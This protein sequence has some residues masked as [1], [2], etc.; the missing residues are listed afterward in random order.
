MAAKFSPAPRCRGLVPELCSPLERAILVQDDSL[1]D[2]CCPG[3]EIRKT[4]VEW[5]YSARFIMIE[6]SDVEMTGNA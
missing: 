6:G 2:Q 4:N 3:Q 1:V 5:R